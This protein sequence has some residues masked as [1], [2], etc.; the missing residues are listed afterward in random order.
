LAVVTLVAL[1]LV[2]IWEM[3]G[4][5]AATIVAAPIFSVCVATLWPARDQG[6][7]LLLSA[8]IASPA[9]FAA[10]GLIARPL[11]DRIVQPQWTIAEQ[12][13]TSSCRT[14][15]SLAPLA[16]LARGRVMAPI[17][18]GSAILAATE[19]SV[20]A[21]PYHRNNDGNLSMFHVMLAAPRTAQQI[22]SDRRV[23]YIVMC[24]GG[25]EQMEFGKLAPDGL[26]ARLGRGE[27]PDFLE[28]LALDRSGKLVAWRVRPAKS[29]P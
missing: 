7:K 20:F 6:R 13:A 5:A 18:L 16:A 3:R 28:P 21:A 27:I 12:D 25:S 2:S 19:H 11:I 17:D 8:L 23:D 9:S 15:S 26:A 4:S 22:L 24:A 14:V 1:V 29:A 10:S